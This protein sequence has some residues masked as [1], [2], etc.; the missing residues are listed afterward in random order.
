MNRK[1]KIIALILS[2][3]MV[4][5]LTSLAGCGKSE[6][7]KHDDYI[8]SIGGVSE[9]YE[10]AVSEQT[11]NSKDDAAKAFVLDEIVG[12][13]DAYISG[14]TSEGELSAN[15]IN[16]VI[17]SNLQEGIESVE[18]MSVCYTADDSSGITLYSADTVTV[19]V[20]KYPT[21]W[22]YYSP[23]PI[24]GETITK[25]YYDSVFDNERYKNCTYASATEMVIKTSASAYGFNVSVKI[26][27]TVDQTIKFANGKIYLSLKTT[28]K[29]SGSDIVV[30]ELKDLNG[31]SL[32]ELYLESTGNSI[33]VHLKEDGGQWQQGTLSQAGFYDLEELTP[34]Y[35]N[36]LDYTYFTKT[37]YGFELSGDRA[38]QYV[39]QT[40]DFEGLFELDDGDF[41]LDIICKYY[42]SD[43]VL[44]GFRQDGNL[45]MN[46]TVDG[47]KTKNSATFASTNTCTDYGTTVVEKPFS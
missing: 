9:T 24:T 37:D 27:I 3:L 14:V 6:T 45:K 44:S 36:Y 11:Y 19:Y 25:S 15:E 38:A 16:D 4:F 7:E 1:H 31:E 47:V 41:D 30:D 12:N 32:M 22:K 21:Y 17:P 10:G 43:G 35:D 29:V 34:F 40:L 13:K 28:T 20:V 18:K 23:A 39:D 5:G 46:F 33:S 2:F 26:A 42:V 8:E